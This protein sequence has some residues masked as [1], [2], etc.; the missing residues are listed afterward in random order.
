MLTI[1]QAKRGAAG[2][3]RRQYAR[4]ERARSIE[5]LNEERQRG[6]ATELRPCETPRPAP[7]FCF[8]NSSLTIFFRI[9]T[10]TKRHSFT[11]IAIRSRIAT[12]VF[13][14]YNW[15]PCAAVE[16]AAER[17]NGLRAATP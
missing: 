15:K 11:Y 5:T 7:R 8:I 14:P 12:K 2:S 3:A 1:V 17:T 9:P 4:L 13:V 6:W 16:R 10:Q